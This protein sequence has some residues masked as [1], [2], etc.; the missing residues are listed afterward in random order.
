M[1]YLL[2]EKS[3]EIIIGES[4]KD[5][6]KDQ[7][8]KQMDLT[9]KQ[10]KQINP[11]QTDDPKKA[12]VFIHDKIGMTRVTFEGRDQILNCNKHLSDQAYEIG[13]SKAG[14]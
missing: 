4:A 11:V 2:N 7:A 9:E 14:Y 13:K 3:Y 8:L 1:I 6:F 10:L 12:K 5:L